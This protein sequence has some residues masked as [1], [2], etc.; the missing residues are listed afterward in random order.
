MLDVAFMLIVVPVAV[1]VP[2]LV[3]YAIIRLAVKHGSLDA[4]RAREAQ[5]PWVAAPRERSG[6][7]DES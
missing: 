5:G 3:L 2:L 6:R 7:P 1:V 4:I